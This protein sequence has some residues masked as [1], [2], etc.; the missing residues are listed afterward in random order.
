M[1][2]RRPHLSY[3]LTTQQAS[4]GVVSASPSLKPQIVPTVA[5]T[6]Q[7]LSIFHHFAFHL[8]SLLSLAKF[9]PVPSPPQPF[10]T[11]AAF[12][13][14]HPPPP[15]PRYIF[16][17]AF[18]ILQTPIP[19]FQFSRTINMTASNQL[20]PIAESEYKV[21]D[22]S[23]AEFG[24]K[25]MD[26]AEVEM[27]GLMSCREEMGPNKP[28]AGAKVMG[29]LHMTI[30]T[31]VLI[32]T[33]KELGADLRWCSCNIFST[34]DHAASAV[35]AKGTASVFAWK[36][37][38]L[39]EY[40]WCTDRALT[41]PDGSGPD[42]IVDDGGDAT[43]LIHEGHKAEITYQKDGTKPDPASTTNAEMK[44]VFRT[45]RDGLESNPKR[46]HDIVDKCVGVSEET[47][48]GVHRLI[49]RA[50]EGSLLFPAINVN[51]CVTKS[52]FD[53][54]YGCRHS[55]PDGIMRATD[56]MLAGKTVMVCGYG[57]VGK[58]S[59]QA[60]KAAGARCVVAEI[61]PI[62]AL[63]ATMEGFQ[64]TTLN[65]IVSEVDIV[66][67][68][69]GNKG[70][71]LI[72]HMAKMKNNAIVG[73]IG[74]FDNEID[75][76]GLESYPGIKQIEIKPQVHRWVFPDGHGIIMLA[77]GRLLNLGC[78]T[79][80]PSF[81]MS[82]SFTNQVLAQVE[83]WDSKDSGKYKKDVYLLPKVLDEKV[84]HLHLPHLNAKLTVLTDEQAE[85]IGVKKEGPYKPETYR[86]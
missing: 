34:Q 44:L 45:I 36:G 60:M 75:I 27:P 11:S 56:V 7:L 79:G 25:E 21:A 81:V 61:D 69:T 20:Y 53:N 23:Q 74:H 5:D 42:I 46:W 22:M 62:C 49:E 16:I 82:F 63:Q 54:V 85:Y 8:F 15:V 28:L 73:N 29:S 17:V 80:H 57:D 18:S 84:A 77:E 66:I 1:S 24:R 31:A 55:L 71:V 3:L 41:W 26:I 33:L 64:V 86:Y 38:S 65:D 83:L 59:A 30:Q 50:R 37:E 43:L 68:T 14:Q 9:L 19:H 78:A 72:D 39:E 13:L 76:A 58:G 35:V 12:P 4:I 67:T 52:K 2:H 70:I 48:T 51:D 40:W 6:P 47:T 32:E 10:K